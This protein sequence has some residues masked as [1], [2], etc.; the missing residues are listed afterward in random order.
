MRLRR[1]RREGADPRLSSR[2]VEMWFAQSGQTPERVVLFHHIPKTAGSSL[3]VLMRE[4]LGGLA[5]VREPF[6]ISHRPSPE[7][8]TWYRTM[9]AS[10]PPDRRRSLVCVTGHGANYLL[11]EIEAPVEAL[12]VLREPV[13]FAISW[14]HFHRRTSHPD[15]AAHLP[16]LESVYERLSG[17]TPGGKGLA[18]RST[19]YFNG[20]ARSLLAPHHDV[21]AL[22]LSDGPPPDADLWRERLFELVEARYW[23]GLREHFAEF[24]GAVAE[25]YGWRAFVPL[26]KV[27]PSRPAVEELPDATRATIRAHNWLD[28]ELHARYARAVA[29]RP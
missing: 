25:R 4:N 26:E 13:D 9:H 21:S 28:V 6:P 19:P 17:A 2:G 22:A 27:N 20:Q 1:T 12:T 11:D 3:R 18:T 5:H 8:Q 23:V 24:A 10:L 16:T 15:R 14:F 7:L 29:S